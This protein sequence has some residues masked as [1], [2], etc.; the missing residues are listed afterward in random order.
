MVPGDRLLIA[1]GYKYNMRKV[2]YFIVIDNTG[3][4]QRGLTYLSKYSD[5]FT[6]V[7]IFPVD[8]LLVMSTYFLLLMRLTPTIN[9]GSL[10]RHWR[11]SGLLSVVGCGYV[12]QFL[13]V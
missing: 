3:I 5:Q 8:R 9:Q 4:T 2:L 12:R 11:S 13:W 6:N 1:I 10:I 7:A